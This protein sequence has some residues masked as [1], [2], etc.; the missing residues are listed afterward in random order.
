MNLDY[1]INE[2]RFNAR[3]SAIIY[4]NDKT[5]VLL[6]KVDDGRDFYMLPGGRIELYEDSIS[7]IRREI[8]EELNYNLDY[9]LCSIQ[10][11]FLE[12]N[13][14]KITQYCFCYKAVYKGKI[15][16]EIIKCNDNNNQSFYWCDIKEINNYKIIPNS[17]YNLILSTKELEHSIE[18]L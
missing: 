14:K 3:V 8:K 17:T 13:N 11:N 15:S 1:E 16:D 9:T 2:Y 7:A 18:R 6:F 10:E 12:K 5:K 4:N